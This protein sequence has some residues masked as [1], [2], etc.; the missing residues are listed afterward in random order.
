MTL[1]L[2]KLCV[3]AESIKS[4]AAWQK[5]RLKDLR[6]AGKKAEL[7][8]VTRMMPKRRDELL[9]GGSLYWVIKGHIAVRQTLIDIRPVTRNGRPY[10]ALVYSARLTPDRK[11]VV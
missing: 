7:I 8:H 4:L 9:D 2:V 11:S 1:N 10:C 6:R 3:G 5:T